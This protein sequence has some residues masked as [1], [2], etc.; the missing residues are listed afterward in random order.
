MLAAVEMRR[1]G[2]RVVLL[3]LFVGAV[4]ALVLATAAG[5]RR[6]GT[7]LERFN[8]SSRT[9][10]LEISVGEPS[11]AE[12]RAFRRVPSVESVAPL[13]GTAMTLSAA[14]GFGATAAAVDNAFGTV[15]D[16]PRLIAG[17]AA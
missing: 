3:V 4:G 6:T 5:A 9:S 16:R 17:R 14:P 11:D 12:M 10:D 7:A 8:S 13:I 1:R 2:A 15:V